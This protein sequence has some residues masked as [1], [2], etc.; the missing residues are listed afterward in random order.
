MLHRCFNVLLVDDEPDVL[1]VSKLAIRR[2]QLYGLPIRVLT[3][4]SKQAAI[5]LLTT[6]PEGSNIA[7][8]IVDVV[9]ESD[10]A[11]L[12]LCGFIREQLDNQVMPLI[13]RTGQAGK[14]PEREVIDRYEITGYINK[15][16]A[17]EGR[18]Y[19]LIKGGVRQYAMAA[20]DHYAQQLLYHL[21]TNLRSPAR[22]RKAVEACLDALGRSPAGVRLDSMLHSHCV[23]GDRFYAGSGDLA[24]A[25]RGRVLRDELGQAPSRAFGVAGDRVHL[26]D[27]ALMVHVEGTADHPLALQS[28]WSIATTPP[29]FVQKTLYMA[30]RQMQVMLNL[31][32]R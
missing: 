8:A 18:L 17:T 23:V 9:M 10:H 25:V 2:M 31:M 3:A 24:D 5:E 13:V 26:R 12:E 32:A 19:S 7:L 1:A 11:G 21:V 28:V 4:G 6:H 27:D 29:A 15:V 14:A 20:Y 16:E 30:T 22:A